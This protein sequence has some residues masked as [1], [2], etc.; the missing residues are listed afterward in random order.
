MNVV[1]STD[2]NFVQHCAVTIVSILKNNPV[3]VNIYVL[4]EGLLEENESILTD[5]VTG[6]GGKIQIIK[7]Q[8]EALKHCPM[9]AISELSHISI[10]TY[11]RLLIPAL[12]PN[13]VDKAIYFDS[14]II[15][16][17]SVKE[18]WSYDLSGFALG[19]VYQ[20]TTWNVAAIRRLGYPI[21]YGYFNAGVLLVNLKYWRENNI[22]NRLFE[23]LNKKS[24]AIIYHDQD[25][26]NG[27]LHA[28]CLRLPCKWNMLTGFFKKNILEINDVDDGEV[29]NSYNDYKEQLLTDKDQPSVIHFVFKP[30][31]WDVGCTHPYK[32]DYFRYIQYTPWHNYKAPKIWYTLFK[33]PKTIYPIFREKIK[34]VIKGSPYFEIFN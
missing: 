34:R 9:P 10:A 31:P 23:Y 12:L 33:S 24:E 19:A 22:V 6:N 13:N 18:L 32:N 25:V 1:C 8:I 27:L 15:V 29:I 2:N 30:K 14:D 26:L 7:V 28:Y 11:Y 21:S 4:T 20:I 16:R 17:D 3:D 5:L